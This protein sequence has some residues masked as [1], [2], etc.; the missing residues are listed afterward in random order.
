MLNDTDRHSEFGSVHMSNKN[1]RCHG[2]KPRKRLLLSL[3]LFVLLAY[4]ACTQG[5][6]WRTSTL[7]YFDTVCQIRLYCSKSEFTEAQATIDKV[8]SDIERLF[9]PDSETYDSPLVLDLYQKALEVHHLSEGFFDISIAPLSRLW[10]FTDKTY[11]VPS[12]EEILAALKIVGLDKI[13]V[14]N[15]RL[16]L[17]KGS[18]I[19]WGGIAKGF[20]VDLASAELIKKGVS[21][22]FINAGGDLF[23][24]G[25][26]PEGLLW[27]IGI[28][29]PRE[30]GFLGV[31]EISDYG[32]ATTGDYQRF[33]VE[34]GTR[35]HHVFN[36]KTGYPA[37][38]R[39]SVTVVG[40]RTILCD[41]LSTALFIHHNPEEILSNY[42]E[43]GAVLVDSQG[44]ITEAGKKLSVR[45]H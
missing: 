27:Q 8:F 5:R 10:G 20:G 14:K 25:K 3:G 39:Q 36:P 7:M 16:I 24:W 33:F 26:N 30:E 41:A 35:Y 15:G 6:I 11:K 29:D 42:P 45:F 31:M 9:S 34:A 43:Y 13:Q 44:I 38:G 19:D 18:K 23:C 40:P 32:A 4:C 21:R 12:T 37:R 2:F 22:G 1:G 28:K 17:P